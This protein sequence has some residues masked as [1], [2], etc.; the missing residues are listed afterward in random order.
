MYTK[1]CLKIKN[2]NFIKKYA[3]TEK[4]DKMCNVEH[5]ALLNMMK[6]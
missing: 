2:Y 6:L 4:L 3:I 5:R 1:N